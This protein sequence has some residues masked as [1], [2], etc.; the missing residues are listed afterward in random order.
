MAVPRG[1]TSALK[2]P[3]KPLK[4]H[5]GNC[6]TLKCSKYQQH[7]IMY[8]LQNTHVCCFMLDNTA[9]PWCKSSKWY[10]SV[11]QHT[12][13]V[14]HNSIFINLHPP[15]AEPAD[16]LPTVASKSNPDLTQHQLD[17]LATVV[18]FR[19]W[20]G[21]ISMGCMWWVQL[22]DILYSKNDK[23]ILLYISKMT[24]C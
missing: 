22:V 8:E 11:C 10:M 15:S 17:M 21:C 4:Q 3:I 19:T 23:D 12:V 20:P 24:C 5:R 14:M 2:L 18:H 1:V 6:D 7:L 16:L 9:S 13:P